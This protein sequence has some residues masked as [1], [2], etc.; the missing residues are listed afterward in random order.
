[1]RAWL[2]TIL[3]MILLGLLISLAY[4][5][6]LKLKDP[7]IFPVKKIHFITN[8]NHIPN[9]LLLQVLR[10]HWRGSFFVFNNTQLR[11]AFM[12]L[13][14][15]KNV[16]MRRLWPD[17]LKISVVEQQPQATWQQKGV[18][19]QTGQLFYPPVASIPKSLP[20]LLGPDA[21]YQQVLQKFH[22]I[23]T[24]LATL[25]LS[26]RSLRLSPRMAWHLELSNGI[27]VM[28]G[29]AGADDRFNRF[30]RLYPRLIGNNGAI[31]AAVDLR[32][33]NGIAIEWRNKST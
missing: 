6:W 17:Q 7:D 11:Q 1:M 21:S 2:Q 25:G 9:S 10:T 26:V 13:P 5:G 23:Q 30:V 4:W 3:P 19:N 14:W 24:I 20:H 22:S 28:M 18:V 31:V 32:Y 8:N 16:S 33:P 12:R 29:R 15:V 27:H